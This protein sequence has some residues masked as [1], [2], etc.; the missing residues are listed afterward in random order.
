M[1]NPRLLSRVTNSLSSILSDNTSDILNS[2]LVSQPQLESVNN[3]DKASIIFTVHAGDPDANDIVAQWMKNRT[4]FMIIQIFVHIHQCRGDAHIGTISPG[5][6][7][8]SDGDFLHWYVPPLVWDILSI[9]TLTVTHS[10]MSQ[11]L[12]YL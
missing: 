11:N 3:S 4:H 12:S 5:T 1:R 7:G 9:E 8:P 6:L 2:S 10:S